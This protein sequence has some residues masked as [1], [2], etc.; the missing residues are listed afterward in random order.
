[1][2]AIVMFGVGSPIV[3]DFEESISRAQL[4]IAAGVINRPEA[5]IF[6]SAKHKT[7]STNEVDDALRDL[8]FLVPLF[9]PGHR[10]T[11]ALEA[12]ALG[13]KTP[14]ALIDRSVA[15]PANFS[16]G[17]GS[18]INSGCSLGA[19]SSF[20]EFV[21]VNRGASI[22]HH[23]QLGKFVSIGPGVVIAGLVSIGF[24]ATIGVGSII[25]PELKIGEN[26]VVAAG[27]VVT[28]NVPQACLVAGNPARIIRRDIGG[29][30]GIAVS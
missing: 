1:M 14:F 2:S 26:A 22:G 24:G 11:A 25:L 16:L 4:S 3:S 9:T 29:F 17:R 21:F 20:A 13:F 8:P 7:L 19:A 27:P 12:A 18:Y 30:K 5:K 10:Q 6:L 28:R 23:T 15:A